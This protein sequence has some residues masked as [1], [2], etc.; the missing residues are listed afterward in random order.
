MIILGHQ[1]KEQMV[2]EW[3]LDYAFIHVYFSAYID[4]C[5]DS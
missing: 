4:M 3:M 5:Q 2:N 1:K